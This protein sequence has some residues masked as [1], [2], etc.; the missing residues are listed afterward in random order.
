MDGP[1]RPKKP[2]CTHVEVQ[3]TLDFSRYPA[4]SRSA[5]GTLCVQFA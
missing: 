1:L 5:D 3:K 4:Y 2:P